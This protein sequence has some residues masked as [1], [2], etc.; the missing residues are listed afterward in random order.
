MLDL[1]D[2][3]EKIVNVGTLNIQRIDSKEYELLQADISFEG[4][5][6]INEVNEINIELKPALLRQQMGSLG[7]DIN[8]Y[9]EYWDD[10]E[11]IIPIKVDGSGAISSRLFSPSTYL[12][13]IYAPGYETHREVVS[14]KKGSGANL[15][16]ITLKRERFIT[17]EYLQQRVKNGNFISKLF[18]KISGN[19][20]ENKKFSFKRRKLSDGSIHPGE[21]WGDQNSLEVRYEKGEWILRNNYHGDCAYDLGAGEVADFLDIS[22]QVLDGCFPSHADSTINK[23]HVYLLRHGSRTRPKSYAL[24]KV[25]SIEVSHF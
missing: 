18:S 16:S 6:K 20:A 23:G 21:S 15:G 10:I 5:N 14:F 1:A 11:D 3:T 2:C 19:N 8:E 9:G 13:S 22:V 12:I 4:I 7:P 24:L 17:F 25:L